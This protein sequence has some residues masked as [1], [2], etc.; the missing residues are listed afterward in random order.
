MRERQPGAVGK[1][2]GNRISAAIWGMLPMSLRIPG[3]LRTTS[4]FWL[5]ALAAC[6]GGGGGGV[7]STPTPTPSTP[8]PSTPTPPPAQTEPPTTTTPTP[9]VTPTTPS[10]PTNFDTTEYRNS[11]GLVQANAITAYNA[12]FTGRGV[13]S[14]I[15]DG[16]I[17]LANG[18]FAG[19]ISAASADVAGSRGTIQDTGGHGTAVAG[20]LGASRNDTGPL[21][22][23]FETTLLIAKSDTP[24]SCATSDGCKHLDSAIARG[25]DLAT[26][27][28]ARVINISLGGS[29]AE[30]VLAQAIGR[31]TAAGIIVV[32]AGGNDA[33]ANPDPLA[34]IANVDAQAHG[35]VIIAGAT[36]QAGD[37]ASFS[38][39]AGNGADHYLMALGERVRSYDQN[40][41]QFLYNG[42]SFSAPLIAGAV[43]LLAQAFPNLTG[44]QIVQLLYSTATDLGAAGT[45]ATYGHGALN[46]TRAFQPQ[47][48]AALAGSA[49]PVSLAGNGTL[50][51]PMGDALAKGGASAVILDG[52]GRAYDYALGAT[53]ARPAPALKLAPALAGGV[54]HRSLAN[55]SGT[56]AMSIAST[57]SDSAVERLMLAPGEAR[58][59][60]AIAGMAASRLSPD[61]AL[62]VGFAQAGAALGDVLRGAQG[63]AFLVSGDPIDTPGFERRAGNGVAL[64]R[65]LGRLGL[66]VT[67]ENGDALVGRTDANDPRRSDLDRHPYAMLAVSV[68]RTVGPLAI[69]AGLSHLRENSTVLGAR[70]G[71][72]FGSGGAATEFADVKATL[73]P[74][75]GLTLGAAMRRGWT[76]MA[77][78]GAAT[79]GSLRSGGYAFDIARL[80]V[81]GRRDRLALRFSQPLRVSSGGYALSLPVAYD[82]ASGAATFAATRLD[83]APQGREHDAE[84]S[85]SAPLLGGWLTTNLYWRTDPGHDA[86]L[87]DDVGGALR[88]ALSF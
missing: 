41:A 74:G 31:A 17:D 32:I 5:L 54:R 57:G 33:S 10:T 72:A 16:G 14:A 56:V 65:T 52:Y 4:A 13:V 37:I 88:Y 44:Q 24:G 2:F 63:D 71:S 53:L 47:G 29:P 30:G 85:W 49:V 59:A 51:A 61:L 66:T 12:G 1:T 60:R 64:R 20:V 43:A 22:M 75:A 76:H 48:Q 83:L 6:G 62:A 28:G 23:A 8:T 25:V 87:P 3:L 40:G 55:G 21:G 80:G 73:S 19:R 36:N 26:A 39:R 81:I 38:D 70:F 84:A 45:D 46:L 58:Q 86:S 11:G 15:V 50:S 42:T 34:Q 27:N 82:Y 18:D 67:A 69:V 77:A 9:P 7:N 79:G 35:L 78:G 68:D